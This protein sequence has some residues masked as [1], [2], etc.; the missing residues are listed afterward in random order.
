MSGYLVRHY[1]W[2]YWEMFLEGISIQIRGSGNV[3]PVWVGSIQ[4]VE[5]LNKQRGRERVSLF[6][7]GSRTPIFSC[8][9]TLA[10][11]LLRPFNWD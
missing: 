5:G 10:P 8:P 9:Q 6:S 3:T 2:A 11:L 4:W 7:A 1:F